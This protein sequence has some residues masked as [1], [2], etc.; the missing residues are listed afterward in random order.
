M[1]ILSEVIGSIRSGRASAR[2][3]T[4][5]G[6]WG[7]RYPP[8]VGVGFH[9]VLAG[10]GF[11]VTRGG[12]SVALEPGSVVLA[13]FGA[14]H[15]LSHAPRPL[16]SLPVASMGPEPPRPAP[17]DFEFLCGCY[18]LDRGQIHR[19]LR[20]LP[21][22]VAIPPDDES[23][24]HLPAMTA[25][26][27][28]DVA[29]DRPGTEAT[30]AA[31]LDLILVHALRR[32]QDRSGGGDWPAVTDAGIAAALR[33]VH[34]EPETQW[35]VQRL[36]DIAGMSRTGFVRRFTA[37]VGKPPMAYVTGWRLTAAARL[38]RETRDPLAAIAQRV[39]YSTEFTF[40]SAFRREYG[41]PPG[42]FRRS[43]QAG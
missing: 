21:D 13:P 20:D 38:L 17:Y 9:I 27:R 36:C 26:L 14:E 15:G 18:R 8:F 31:L 6:A 4:E 24:P 16:A 10:T 11:L 22:V 39:G 2:R 19:F 42:R 12:S 40:A 3:I 41:L 34:D 33:A 37:L 1:D 7:A 35:T 43:V 23:H 5:S 25:L 32:W 28:D 30:R 29:E